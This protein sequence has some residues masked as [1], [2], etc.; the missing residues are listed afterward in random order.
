M[1]VGSGTSGM[2]GLVQFG[3]YLYGPRRWVNVGD[4]RIAIREETRHLTAARTSGR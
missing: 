2:V 1:T 4:V 3:P